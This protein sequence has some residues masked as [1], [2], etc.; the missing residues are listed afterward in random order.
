MMQLV[1][2]TEPLLSIL[3]QNFH[4]MTEFWR[5]PGWSILKNAESMTLQW[6]SSFLQRF[7][8]HLQMSVEEQEKLRE[9]F[10]DYQLLSNDGIPQHVWNDAT[11]K[12]DGDRNACLF[13]MDVI[14]GQLNATKSADG[15]PRFDLLARVALT[16]LCLPHSNAEEER[17]FSMTGKNKQ[18]ECSSLEVKETLSSIMTV[19]LA[20]LNAEIFTPP[21][22]VLKAAKSATYEY[23]TAHKCK[24]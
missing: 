4:L 22:S 13:H 2:F 12:I 16:V 10:I 1:D 6:P 5:I 7:P 17:V 14:W 3:W 18:A 11:V 19:K 23:N 15:A 8:R 24:L 20:D 9:Q 21:A